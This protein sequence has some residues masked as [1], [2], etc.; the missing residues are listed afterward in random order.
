MA[1][2]LDPDKAE[3]PMAR[4]ELLNRLG[5]WRDALV[6]ARRAVS[7]QPRPP[8]RDRWGGLVKTI[9]MER[10]RQVSDSPGSVAALLDLAKVQL[11]RGR[12]SAAEDSCLQAL[13]LDPVSIPTYE[14]LAD[15]YEAFGDLELALGALER[16]E[17]IDPVSANERRIVALRSRVNAAIEKFL[18]AER[19][20]SSGHA[21]QALHEA[22]EA[23]EV[24]PRHA[25]GHLL[26]GNIHYTLGDYS[27]AI[28]AFDQAV[29]LDPESAD[30]HALRGNMLYQLGCFAEALQAY[31]EA[32][33]LDPSHQVA[34][35]NRDALA[36]AS[37]T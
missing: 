20:F 34:R 15:V 26:R 36:H 33:R 4:A 37:W 29:S 9:E 2:D 3:Y 35:R 19:L 6:E 25:P 30:A 18:L 27:E 24:L 16:I 23:L 31:E 14:M 7:I 10:R 11:E 1:A 22:D 5:R 8:I 13:A 28:T 32:I 12:H 17:A 21:Q